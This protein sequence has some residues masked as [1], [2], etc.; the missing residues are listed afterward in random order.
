MHQPRSDQLPNILATVTTV[1]FYL[2]VAGAA[3]VLVVI[4]IMKV[5]GA[6]NQEWYW[7]IPVS[8][9][10]R[11]T[12]ASVATSWDGTVLRI[13]DIRGSLRLPLGPLPWSLFVLLWLHVAVIAGLVLAMLHQLR[14][15]FRSVRE[16]TPFDA[17]NAVRLR[18]LGL[19]LLALA[20]LNTV[21]GAAISLAVRGAVADGSVRVPASLNVDM[22]M[23]FVALVLLALAEIFR[24]G[25]EL[26]HESALVI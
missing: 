21:A 23:V 9:V 6:E 16:G 10:A 13:D 26:E 22:T 5:A 3:F 20:I 19:L 7:G 14:Q 4:P 15:L 24:R 12:E 25:A 2:A 1:L 18:W 17:T 11:E 8:A